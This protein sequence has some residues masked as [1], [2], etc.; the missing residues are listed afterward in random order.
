M[1]ALIQGK[2]GVRQG[3]GRSQTDGGQISARPRAAERPDALTL[4]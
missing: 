4:L 1:Q 3:Q 2:N